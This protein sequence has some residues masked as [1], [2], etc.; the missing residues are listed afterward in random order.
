MILCFDI[1]NTKTA[2]ALYNDNVLCKIFDYPTHKTIAIEKIE[3]IKELAVQIDQ[4]YPQ[5]TS[6]IE[7]MAYS[8][9]VMQKNKE[10]IDFAEKLNIPKVVKID[11]NC[12]LKVPMHYNLEQIGADRIAN[13]EEANAKYGQNVV[14]ADIGTA[15]TLDVI[16]K[17]IFTGGLILP[18]LNSAFKSLNKDTDAIKNVKFEDVPEQLIGNNTADCI[19]SGIYFGWVSM[20]EGLFEKIKASYNQDFTLVL[21]GGFSQVLSPHILMPHVVD[22]MLTLDG[23]YRVYLNN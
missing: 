11:Q 1:G 9:V 17:G 14:V 19:K 7:G 10:Y 6:K 13:I 12:K 23:V 20:I 4:E 15:L 21:T 5:K 16:K 22:R 18:G 3:E 2:C 8:S